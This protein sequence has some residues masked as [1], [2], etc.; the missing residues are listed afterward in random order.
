M[1]QFGIIGLGNIG[2]VHMGNLAAG[3]IRRGTLKAVSDLRAPKDRLPD[4]VTYFA[5]V[6]EMLRSGT[7]DAVIVATPHPLHLALGEKVLRHGLHLMMEKPL[8]A[9]K[10]DGER[11][12][13]VPRKPGQVFAIMMNLRTHPHYRRIKG[14]L[15]AGMLGELQRVQWTITNWFRPEAYYRLSDWRATWKGEGGGV[16]INQ[17]LH[18]LDVLQWLCGMP[19]RVRACC[20]FGHDHDIEVEDSVL[21]YGEYPNG[22]T[23]LF[24]TSTGE[25][26][27]VNRLEIA[28]TRALVVLENDVLRL[29]TNALDI[30]EYSRT[31]D[32]AFG[33]PPVEVQEFALT[34]VN[35]SHSGVLNNFVDAILDGAALLADASEGLRSVELANAMVY[36]GWKQE[37]VTL[38]LDA[39]AYEA[40]LQAAIASTKPRQ[41]LIREAHVDMQKSY[42]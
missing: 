7:V 13:A 1:L 19:D 18:N 38:P 26:P 6:E 29:S 16:L 34:E 2:K 9:T 31:T 25:A 42:S 37:A 5:D 28:G 30:R 24:T 41:R 27:G 33:M 15:D 12:L 23:C 39:A 22:A 10:L 32:N 17:A 14:W 11:L 35:P 21:A 40:A 3:K 4:G 36:S 20:R 8:T